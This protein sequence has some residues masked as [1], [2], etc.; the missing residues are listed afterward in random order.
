PTPEPKP[1]PKKPV[2]PTL[3][4]KAVVARVLHAVGGPATNVGR[5]F[6][7]GEALVTARAEYL[8]AAVE[9]MG[10]LYLRENTQAEIGAAG[11][12]VLHDGELLARFE[13]KR[14]GTLKTPV[15]AVE[16]HAPI[17]NVLT[18]KSSAEISIPAGRV[19]MA[20]TTSAG[21]STMM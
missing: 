14:Q 10:R 11:E 3:V 16:V 6:H 12:I 18:S 21:P 9:G 17:V 2:P 8:D 7:A 13:G 5:V 15:G 4:E 19:I 20:T 1:E